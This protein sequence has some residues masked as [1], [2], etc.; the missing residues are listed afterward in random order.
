LR[1]RYHLDRSVD[2]GAA[3]LALRRLACR[4]S[5]IERQI[6]STYANDV[7]LAMKT[8][9]GRA[10]RFRGLKNFRAPIEAATAR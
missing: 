4:A 8:L 3:T 9:G 5:T 10:A 7:D 2:E 6:E 1:R